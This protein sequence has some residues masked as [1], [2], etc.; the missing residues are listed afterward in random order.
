MRPP[1]RSAIEHSFRSN[2]NRL[3]AAS[4]SARQEVQRFGQAIA[5]PKMSFADRARRTTIHRHRPQQSR[6]RQIEGERR[7][8]PSVTD[9]QRWPILALGL[10][11]LTPTRNGNLFLP[12]PRIRDGDQKKPG[13]RS[14]PY[15]VNKSPTKTTAPQREAII[16]SRSALASVREKR[17]RVWTIAIISPASAFVCNKRDNDS[18]SFPAIFTE[19]QKRFQDRFAG[20]LRGLFS[21]LSPPRLISTK[22]R[23]WLISE[24][25]CRC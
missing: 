9:C 3:R 21:G 10:D 7:S 1:R 11:I 16:L 17:E 20:N 23:H 14:K 15:V 13:L 6:T 4:S 12:R 18:E 22:S 2:L 24:C 19:C 5:W 25:P 8:W